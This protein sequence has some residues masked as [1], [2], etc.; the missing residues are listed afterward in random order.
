[1]IFDSYVPRAPLSSFVADFWLYQNYAGS[2]ERELIVPSGTFEMVFNLEENELRIY[3]PADPRQCRRFSG[4]I[5]SGP[6]SRSF[7]SDGAEEKSLLG[8]HFRPGGAAGFLGL[9]AAE[10]RD[11]HVDL[12]TIWGSAAEILRER[13]CELQEPSSKFRCLEQALTR[14]LAKYTGG[15]DAV[16]IAL[17][18][19]TRTQGR[20][21][22]QDLARAAELSQ[23]R[24]IAL[25]AGEVGLTPKVFGRIT[26]FQHAIARSRNTPEIDW[27]RLALEC[28]YYDQSHLIRDFVAFAGVTPD[29]Y[30]HRHDRLESAGLHTKRHHLPMAR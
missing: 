2:H 10:F 7:M 20:A 16:G 18:G 4:A 5:V 6:Y 23:R 13:L 29:D 14:R 11:E 24:M 27:A 8:V 30:R 15:H 22:T 3:D 17:D 26:R 25:F 19:I 1:M 12:R 28:G 21:R 9:P